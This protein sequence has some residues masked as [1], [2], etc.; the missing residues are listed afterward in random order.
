LIPLIDFIHHFKAIVRL[1]YPPESNLI[2]IVV[3]FDCSFIIMH[4]VFECNYLHEM[5]QCHCSLLFQLFLKHPFFELNNIIPVG[6]KL[7]NHVLV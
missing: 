7:I 5:A 3:D 4:K 1:F 2:M 6:Q